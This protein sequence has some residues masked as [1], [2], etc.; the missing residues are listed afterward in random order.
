MSPL[1]Q[2]LT[3]LLGKLFLHS[4]VVGVE[5]MVKTGVGNGFTQLLVKVQYI[6][7]NL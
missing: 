3:I 2:T 1:L 7:Y 6:K 5:L 4:D